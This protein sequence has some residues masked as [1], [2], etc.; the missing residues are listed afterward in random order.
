MIHY[1]RWGVLTRNP[2]NLFIFSP[3]PMFDYLAKSSISCNCAIILGASYCKV[4]S[5]TMDSLNSDVKIYR[6]VYLGIKNISLYACMC[7]LIYMWGYTESLETVILDALKVSPDFL[8]VM[9]ISQLSK[10]L[11]QL[12]LE[13]H[14]S[15][16]S[17]FL[18]GLSK[19]SSHLNRQVWYYRLQTSI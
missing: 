13:I 9:I 5:L 4:L 16:I 14:E 11:F 19:G 10:W 17:R 8:V 12:I 3:S 18:F 2:P 15:A 1:Y 6:N 7:L